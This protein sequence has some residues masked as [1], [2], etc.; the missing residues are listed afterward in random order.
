MPTVLLPRCTV[1]VAVEVVDIDA[2]NSRMTGTAVPGRLWAIARLCAGSRG[3]KEATRV[4]RFVTA[5]AASSAG[6][7]MLA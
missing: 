4:T 6:V 5:N 2:D 7:V 1:A 3:L